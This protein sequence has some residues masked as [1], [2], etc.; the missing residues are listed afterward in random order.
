MSCL[1]Y[2]SSHLLLIPSL[3]LG[4]QP[5][6]LLT[7]PLVVLSPFALVFLGLL[8]WSIGSA[9][10]QRIGPRRI[11]G[12]SVAVLLLT[13]LVV[14]LLGRVHAQF[15]SVACPPWGKPI[16]VDAFTSLPRKRSA[17]VSYTHLDVYKRQS[18]R[19]FKIANKT[20][21]GFA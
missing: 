9:V 14:A 4:K 16:V 11:V 8:L 1:L 5:W 10:E 20:L 15:A 18:Q 3:A 2:T 6:R 17:P 13:S 19:D 12:W 7:A 21:C